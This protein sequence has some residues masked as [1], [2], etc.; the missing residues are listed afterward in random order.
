MAADLPVAS[1]DA[2]HV[3][4]SIAVAEFTLLLYGKELMNINIYPFPF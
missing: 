1:G 4:Q 3:K 2:A